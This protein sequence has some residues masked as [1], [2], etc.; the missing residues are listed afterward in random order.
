MLTW[1]Q[2]SPNAAQL[3]WIA[4]EQCVALGR[5]SLR[6]H[7]EPK[8]H[9]PWL[10]SQPPPPW[11]GI[12][13]TNNGHPSPQLLCESLIGGKKSSKSFSPTCKYQVSVDK[14]KRVSP[15]RSLH[16]G[17][18]AVNNGALV[19]N[20][21][22]WEGKVLVSTLHKAAFTFVEKEKQSRSQN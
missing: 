7:N 22:L 10:A 16:C 19:I 17:M 12:R 21:V 13:E 6:D 11:T 20:G 9:S 1:F 8:E 3:F 4:L 14:E 15:L 18:A 5:A 2:D